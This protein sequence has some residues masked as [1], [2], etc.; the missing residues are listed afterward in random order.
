MMILPLADAL[1]NCLQNLTS[2]IAGVDNE[3]MTNR[4]IGMGAMLGYSVGAIKEQFKTPESNINKPNSNNNND[5]GNSFLGRVKNIINPTMNLTDEKDYNENVNPIRNTIKTDSP[6][7]NNSI[8]LK[9]ISNPNNIKNI[10]DFASKVTKTGYKITK[11]YLKVGAD[12]VEGNFHPEKH[13]PKPPTNNKF[14]PKTIQT[15]EYA[16]NVSK[17]IHTEMG[18]ENEH[19]TSN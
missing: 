6:I 7:N 13:S 16:N 3:Q 11:N 8:T 10:G 1:Q 4:V 2:R 5:T 14:N 18:D 17:L 15:T 12:L 9:N 19:N